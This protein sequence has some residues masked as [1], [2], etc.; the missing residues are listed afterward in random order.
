MHRAQRAAGGPLAAL[1][2]TA[3]AIELIRPARIARRVTVELLS[4]PFVAPFAWDCQQVLCHHAFG[5]QPL[6]L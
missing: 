5:G 4:A 2:T 3:S 6:R 1:D